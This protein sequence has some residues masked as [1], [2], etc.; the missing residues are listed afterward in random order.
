M[1]KKFLTAP[2]EVKAFDDAGVFEGYASVFG[3]VDSDGDVISKGAF[4]KSLTQYG[5]S[6]R[7]PKMLWMHKT[8]QIIGKW[9]EIREDDTGLYVKG[10][11]IMEVQKGREAYALLKAGELD[12]MSV[13]FN[14]DSATPRGTK[15]NNINELSLWEISLVTWGA[16]P[17]ARVSEVK[18]EKEFERFLRDAGFSRKEATTITSYG[19]KASLDLSDSGSD[20]LES[21]KTLFNQMRSASR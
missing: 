14:V 4:K 15:G 3:V 17:E 1:E 8:D 5:E 11:L 7:R 20:E 6:N 10:S 2:L 18:S 13:G 21:L 12:S 9:Q 16:N 19:Y